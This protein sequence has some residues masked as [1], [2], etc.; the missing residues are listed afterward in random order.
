MSSIVALSCAVA[1]LVLLTGCTV[2][3]AV[4]RA[5]DA[6]RRVHL[7]LR[8]GKVGLTLD[9]GEVVAPPARD[10]PGTAQGVRPERR[11]ERPTGT[12]LPPGNDSLFEHSDL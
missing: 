11:W 6:G 7:A 4:L 8:L 9:A 2:P 1:V 3:I 10:G 5:I 12:V